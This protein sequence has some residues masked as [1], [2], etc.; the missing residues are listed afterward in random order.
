MF[1][2][3]TNKLFDFLFD[4]GSTFPPNFEREL[5]ISTLLRARFFLTTLPDIDQ[6]PRN[7]RVISKTI[8]HT[9]LHSMTSITTHLECAL[10]TLLTVLNLLDQNFAHEIEAR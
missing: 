10:I 1:V 6:F 5:Y 7:L 4:E 8:C 9:N 3:M 2:M